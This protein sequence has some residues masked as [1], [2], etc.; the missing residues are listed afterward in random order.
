MR[1]AG[2]PREARLRRA[3]DFAAQRHASG[4]FGGRC[5]SV[6]Y[7]PN[8][9]DHPRLGLAIS[10]RVSKRAV[11]RNRLKRLVRESFRRHRLELP[12]IDLMVMAREQAVSL[13]GPELLDEL[14]LL[15]KKL[16]SVR[17]EATLKPGDAAGTIVR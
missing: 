14:Q 11:D 9:L 15:W 4:R 16:R 12:P 2:L 3:G 10:K 1:A 8:G 7:R 5:F 6:R 13:P 17:L